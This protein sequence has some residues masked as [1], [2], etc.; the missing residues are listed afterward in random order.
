MNPRLYLLKSGRLVLGTVVSK[1][2]NPL[3]VANPYKTRPS[4]LTL[5]VKLATKQETESRTRRMMVS[6]RVAESHEP[7]LVK[8]GIRSWK[9]KRVPVGRRLAKLAVP[10]RVWD[11]ARCEKED[12][13][14]RL[15]GV[16]GSWSLP[17]PLPLLLEASLGA[18]ADGRLADGVLVLNSDIFEGNTRWTADQTSVC[19]AGRRW[20]AEE[21]QRRSL[22]DE[23]GV[24][25]WDCEYEVVRT[26]EIG[27][28]VYI[29]SFRLKR[30]E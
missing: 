2:Y 6:G 7:L 20:M 5:S 14:W 15:L 19:G 18:G 4:A 23:D 10:V 9:A 3:A 16:S 13:R 25:V 29:S 1:M 28:H 21:I 8:T 17:L 11:M 26:K 24:S 27:R 22:A 30:T 12:G